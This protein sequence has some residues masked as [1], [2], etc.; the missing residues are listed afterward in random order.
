MKKIPINREIFS[1]TE[2]YWI[3]LIV[4]FAG[5]A[6]LIW[7]LLIPRGLVEY[8]LGVNLFTSSIFMVLT[9]VFLSLLFSLRDRRQWKSVENLV[10]L[11]IQGDLGL[12]FY[13]ILRFSENGSEI[14]NSILSIEDPETQKK[15]LVAELRKLNQGKGI[16]LNP[17]FLKLVLAKSPPEPF[18]SIRKRLGEIQ[19]KYERFLSPKLTYALMGIQ[20]ALVLFETISEFNTTITKTPNLF[21]GTFQNID[22]N[23]PIEFSCQTIIAEIYSI[24]EIGIDFLFYLIPEPV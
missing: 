12:L 5:L 3:I 9:I 24:H 13:S 18:S 20:Q 17:N 15:N 22:W 8:N 6:M 10:R 4:V 2:A 19:L 14:I 21:S 23:K 16:K 11:D 7:F 1:K